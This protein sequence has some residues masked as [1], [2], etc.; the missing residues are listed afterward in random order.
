INEGGYEKNQEGFFNQAKN[1]TGKVTTDFNGKD[2]GG[3]SITIQDDGK[4]L[5]VGVSNNGTD[6][7]FAIARYN[8]DGS[9]DTTFNST[10]KVTAVGV[11]NRISVICLLTS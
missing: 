2:E 9:L 11:G 5:V 3:Y 1:T 7:D 8:S 4:I 6:D 10:G